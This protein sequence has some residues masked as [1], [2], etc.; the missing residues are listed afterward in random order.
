MEDQTNLYCDP[1]INYSRQETAAFLDTSVSMV[2]KLIKEGVILTNKNHKV[3]GSNIYHYLDHRNPE[4]IGKLGFYP[5]WLK[6]HESTTLESVI[7]EDD[8][9]VP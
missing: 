8:T 7:K 3:P 2:K 9:K 6:W 1:R 4:R 5:S